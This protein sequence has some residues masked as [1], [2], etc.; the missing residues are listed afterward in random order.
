MAYC[1]KKFEQVEKVEPE[2]VMLA[3]LI[4]EIEQEEAEIQ[5]TLKEKTPIKPNVE[6]TEENKGYETMNFDNVESDV[7]NFKV[8]KIGSG[9]RKEISFGMGGITTGDEGG[10]ISI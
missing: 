5:Q 3:G 2:P 4:A 10:H 7:N 8:R 9:L 6:N 1:K